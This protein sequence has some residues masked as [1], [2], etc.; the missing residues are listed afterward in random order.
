MSL[1]VDTGA[2]IALAD[3]RD[4]YHS[5]VLASVE[6]TSEP[7][8]IPVTVL[9]EADYLLTRDIGPSAAV[10][11]LRSVQMGEFQL[12]SLVPTDLTRCIELLSQYAD[13]NI[14][15]VDASIAAIAERLRITRILTLDRRHFRLLRP[16]HCA[17]FELLPGSV[18]R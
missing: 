10:A 7:L 9:P 13:S 1:L 15:F 17:A 2:L 4:R 12:E 3:A 14:G 16:R 11:V 6:G 18:S 5:D 8:L